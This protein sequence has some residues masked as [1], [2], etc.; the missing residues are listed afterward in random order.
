MLTK[1]FLRRDT[2]GSGDGEEVPSTREFL[3]PDGALRL[4]FPGSIEWVIVAELFGWL[5][6]LTCCF[7]I[8]YHLWSG[9]G[10]VWILVS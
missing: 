9:P 7:L 5:I 1:V 3:V 8:H 2:R 10:G 6:Q 4:L